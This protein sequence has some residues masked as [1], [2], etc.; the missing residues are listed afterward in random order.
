MIYKNRDIKADINVNGVDIGNV[1][2]NFYTKDIGTSSIRINISWY[3]KPF[4][5][6]NTNFTPKLDLFC[7]DGSIFLDEKLEI[8]SQ[9]NGLVQYN[10]SDSVIRHPGKVRAKL[11][12]TNEKESIHALNFD[13]TIVDSGVDS[14]ISKE[15]SVNLV[16]DAVRRI[17]KEN[18]IELLGKDFKSNLNAEIIDYLNVNSEKFKGRAFE[19][20]DFTEEQLNALKGEQG[21]KGLKGEQGVQGIP[22]PQGP[23]GEQGP[24]GPMGE[25]GAQGDIGPR[26]EQGVP[27]ERGQQGI[28]GAQGPKGERGE[29][30]PK[31]PQGERGLQGIPGSNGE[32]GP[33]GKDAVIFDTG[34]IDLN[35]INGTQSYYDSSSPKY[36]LVQTGGVFT[37]SFNGAVRNI[38]STPLVIATL[39]SNIS[40]KI[41]NDIPFVQNTSIKGGNASF[42]RWTIKVNGNIE[43][44]RT[45]EGN[46]S[47]NVSDYFPISTTILL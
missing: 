38:T 16:D 2:A 32:Q 25:K 43:L 40:E 14:T 39:P 11:F 4:D 17:I 8:V 20:S 36:R 42:A 1:D 23:P 9:V 28:A 27:G 35:L 37:L 5:L 45:S 19:Y 24:P 34:W 10:I 3:G 12:L 18:A 22:G 47:L 21:S 29:V 13:F 15:V 31:G 6:S 41:T 46:G 7:E 30:G 44:F 33:P 26:G